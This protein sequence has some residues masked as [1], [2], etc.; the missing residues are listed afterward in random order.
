MEE[1]K[2]NF[3]PQFQKQQV[4]VFTGLMFSSFADILST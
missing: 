4:K 2:S 3:S 1:A